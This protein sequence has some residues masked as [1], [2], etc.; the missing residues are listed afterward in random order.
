MIQGD[1]FVLTYKGHLTQGQGHVEGA[2]E[3]PHLYLERNF[4]PRTFV[5]GWDKG[6]LC[7]TPNSV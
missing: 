4:P 1:I 7:G 2:Q 3:I 6:S 5:L